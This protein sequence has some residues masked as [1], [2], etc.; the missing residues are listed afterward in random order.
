MDTSACR[1]YFLSGVLNRARQFK[2]PVCIYSFPVPYPT[3]YALR[4]C[5][6]ASAGS[7]SSSYTVLNCLS[8]IFPPNS[9]KGS[10]LNAFVFLVVSRNRTLFVTFKGKMF[11][12]EA[13]LTVDAVCPCFV[14]SEV[15]KIMHL[16]FLN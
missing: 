10:N 4:P 7:R 3:S 8:T 6:R 1:R 9:A 14:K 15:L 16:N 11:L 5:P 2:S 12:V 13:L